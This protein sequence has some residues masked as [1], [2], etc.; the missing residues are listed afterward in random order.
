MAASRKY[1][2][3]TLGCAKNTVDSDSMAALL[4]R[5]GWKP[6]RSASEADA[7]IVNT[8]GF[9]GPARAESIA[10]LR[11]L[12]AAKRPRQRLI[13]AGCL[14][15]RAGEALAR[16]VPGLDGVM[17]T[18]RWMD[19]LAVVERLD[20]DAAA[21]PLIHLPPAPAVGTDEQGVVRA[22]VRGA[23]AY[24]KI[25]DGCRRPCAF[26]AI[27]AIKGPPVSRPVERIL[28]E[29]RILQDG[30]V[31]ELVL[32]A[33]D[34]TGYGLDLGLRDGLPVLLERIASAAPRI[35]WIRI[36]YAFPG[37]VS[38]RLID[39]MAEIPQAV[40][41]LDI[42]LQHADPEILRRMRRPAD[43]DEVRRTIGRMRRRM[44]DLAVRTA[45]IVGFPGETPAQFDALLAF[46][47][48]MRFDRVGC[49][50][51]S[52]EAGTPAAALPD[53]VPPDEKR[54]RRDRLMEL[55][56]E[57]SE[58]KNREWIGRSLDVLIEG[59]QKELAVGRSFRDAPEVDGLVFVEGAAP[60]GAM[61]R[62]RVTGALPYDLIGVPEKE[63]RPGEKPGRR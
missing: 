14:S 10:E 9:I 48:K 43:V 26:C 56:Q 6:A 58:A 47:R 1:Y 29:A 33:Q 39:A 27:P 36:L 54:R 42:P 61:I 15:Q 13:A 23:S 31:R 32:L 8:C 57:I 45:F 37:A 3:L 24:L 53:D 22:A 52:R 4:G 51:Y 46:L 34:T 41:Y 11:K 21:P 44:P 25:A 17:G 50:L 59:K 63:E 2:L 62:I 38:P 18:R 5:G 55:Q 35:E 49:F 20:S 30:G 40:P 19:I 7:L 12:A 60:P 28:E 16:E